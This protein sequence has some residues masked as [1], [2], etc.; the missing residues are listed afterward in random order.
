MKNCAVFI[1]VEGLSENL[2]LWKLKKAN[3]YVFFDQK[4]KKKEFD[5]LK[6]CNMG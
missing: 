2:V 3:I 6:N 1:V 4:K 5:V